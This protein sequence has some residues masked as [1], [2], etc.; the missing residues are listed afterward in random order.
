MGSFRAKSL[1]PAGTCLL[2]AASAK[3]G[4]RGWVRVRHADFPLTSSR[5]YIVI[6]G[7]AED[8][9]TLL[10]VSKDLQGE[11]GEVVKSYVGMSICSLSF[12]GREPSSPGESTRFL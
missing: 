11:G 9:V 10:N 12:E 2:E 8:E 5:D 1:S 7:M 6:K 3:A 4:E